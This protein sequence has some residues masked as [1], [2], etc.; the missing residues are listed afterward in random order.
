M[1]NAPQFVCICTVAVVDVMRP[2]GRVWFAS[3]LRSPGSWTRLQPAGSDSPAVRTMLELDLLALLL[4]LSPPPQAATSTHSP[5]A[6]RSVTMAR[7][8]RARIM[9]TLPVPAASPMSAYEHVLL[10][11]DGVVWV[12]DEPTPP[13]RRSSG[14]APGRP[15]APAGRSPPCAARARRRLSSRTAAATARTTSSASS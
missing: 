10:D 9:P 12:G 15:P 14:G 11:L 2:R 13:A 3:F 5:P 1:V 6:T 4:S 8:T 7:D